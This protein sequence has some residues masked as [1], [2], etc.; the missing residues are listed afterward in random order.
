MRKNRIKLVFVLLLA[1]FLSSCDVVNP[2]PTVTPTPTS[3]LKPSPTLT[4]TITPTMTITSTITPTS[5]LTSTP[6]ATPIIGVE[7]PIIVDYGPVILHTVGIED[8]I[9]SQSGPNL[10][11]YGYVFLAIL[12]GRQDLDDSWINRVT[13]ICDN[14]SFQPESTYYIGM[15]QIGDYIPN[16]EIFFEIPQDLAYKDCIFNID[17]FEIRLEP[18][19]NQSDS[20]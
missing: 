10:P 6:S 11:R 2:E 18:L 13:L 17:S 14:Q 16:Y 12:V 15:F 5:T 8:E 7:E 19:L 20:N 1:L 9:A 3:T 4:M